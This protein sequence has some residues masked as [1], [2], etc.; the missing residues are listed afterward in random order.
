[1]FITPVEPKQI[2]EYNLF[3]ALAQSY[4][5]KIRGDLSYLRSILIEKTGG[6]EAVSSRVVDEVFSNKREKQILFSRITEPTIENILKRVLRYLEGDIIVKT[7]R[8]DY[9]ASI[10]A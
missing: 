9:R 7:D 3:N 1:V 2:D 4:N 5:R 8:K 6:S 10:M